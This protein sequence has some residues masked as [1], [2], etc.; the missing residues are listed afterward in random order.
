MKIKTLAG[1]AA[2]AVAAAGMSLGMMAGPA[3]AGPVEDAVETFQ[4]LYWG[5]ISPALRDAQEPVYKAVAD[6]QA[7]VDEDVAYVQ[8]CFDDYGVLFPFYC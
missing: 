3:S 1:R 6:A 2:V 8:N 5:T 4:D 7:I